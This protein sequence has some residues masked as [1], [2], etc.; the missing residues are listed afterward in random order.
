MKILFSPLNSQHSLP[1]DGT[2]NSFP[3][4]LSEVFLHINVCLF[5]TNRNGITP[6]RYISPNVTMFKPL[7]AKLICMENFY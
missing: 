1:R 2:F 6:Y 5:F 3:P 4:T 7:L